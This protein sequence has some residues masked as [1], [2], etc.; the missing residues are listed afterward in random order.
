MTEIKC[1][2]LEQQLYDVF[3]K[4]ADK[5]RSIRFFGASLICRAASSIIWLLVAPLKKGPT[6][7]S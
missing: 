5:Q 1:R 3:R 7:K 4:Y 2:E 6:I